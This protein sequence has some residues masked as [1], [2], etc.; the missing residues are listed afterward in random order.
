MEGSFNLTGTSEAIDR[1]RKV[2]PD[3]DMFE[4]EDDAKEI[5]K[6]LYEAYL[7][8]D[9]EYVSKVCDNEARGF[10]LASI[11]GWEEMEVKPKYEIIWSIDSFSLMSKHPY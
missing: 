3:F 4:L 7:N 1:M 5:F 11:R 2:D 9:G 8:R 6:R 10:F